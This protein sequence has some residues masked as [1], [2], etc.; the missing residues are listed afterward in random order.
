MQTRSRLKIETGGERLKTVKHLAPVELFFAA[1]VTDGN[2]D[3]SN[4]LVLRLAGDDQFYFLFPKGTE[5]G[6]KKPAT[7]L[8]K[9]LKRMAPVGIGQGVPEEAV[10]KIPTGSPLES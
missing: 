7:W 4:R 10:T 6:L 8:Q 1:V 5:E 9:V 3:V 2:G